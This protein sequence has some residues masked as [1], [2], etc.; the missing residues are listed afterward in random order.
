MARGHQKIEAQKKNQAKLAAQKGGTSNLKTR[1]AGLKTVCPKC[2][3]PMSDYTNFKE[4]WNA[5]HDKF[6]L[7]S[8]EEMAAKAK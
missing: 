7:P 6:P 3:T 5:R 8:E 4:H 1:A 2:F